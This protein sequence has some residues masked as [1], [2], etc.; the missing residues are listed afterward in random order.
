MK[1]LARMT[2]RLK[3]GISGTLPS[4]ALAEGNLPKMR[5]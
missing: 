5:L 2:K 3:N 4:V 1:N